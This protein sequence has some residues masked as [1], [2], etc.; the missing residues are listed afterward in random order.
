[1]I[2]PRMPIVAA[3]SANHLAALVLPPGL[4]RLYVAHD[5]DPAG[6]GATD[7]LTRRAIEAGIEG[8]TLAPRLGDF[9]DDLL[10][11]GASALSDHLRLQLAPD[12]V[13]KFWTPP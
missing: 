11:V 4:R 6:H 7:H 12:D 2:L 8:L 10:R 1:M 13:A 9:N 3:L 5:N